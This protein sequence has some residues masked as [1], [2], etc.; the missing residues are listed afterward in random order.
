MTFVSMSFYC[1]CISK[2]IRPATLFVVE[3][4]SCYIRFSGAWVSV[5]MPRFMYSGFHQR[6][7]PR[8]SRDTLI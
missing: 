3:P 1:C 8:C 5:L 4:V 2:S 6:A 7:Q